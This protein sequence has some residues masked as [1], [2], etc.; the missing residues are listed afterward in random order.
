ML[1]RS[2]ALSVTVMVPEPARPGR[3]VAAL[4]YGSAENSSFCRVWPKA[5]EVPAFGATSPWAGSGCGG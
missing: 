5:V 4:R 1:T 3:T 2:S